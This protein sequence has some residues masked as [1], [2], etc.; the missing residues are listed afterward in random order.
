MDEALKEIGKGLISLANM[1]LVIFFLNNIFANKMDFNLQILSLM[2][3]MFSML[4]LS[5]IFLIKSGREKERKSNE[6]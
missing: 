1:L 5:G 2:L 6:Y 3:Y 4:Y